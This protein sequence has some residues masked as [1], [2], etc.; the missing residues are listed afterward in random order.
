MGRN[1]NDATAAVINTG[2]NLEDVPVSTM[3]LM[4]NFVSAFSLLN[5]L[6]KTIPFNTATPKRAINPTPA[7]ILNGK[8]LIHN[9]TIPPMAERGMAV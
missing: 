8:S 7:E 2:L 6:I 4:L 9:K 3:S 1:P 5:S